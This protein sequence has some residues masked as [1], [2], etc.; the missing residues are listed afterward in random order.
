MEE[1]EKLKSIQKFCEEIWSPQ[2]STEKE[3]TTDAQCQGNMAGPKSYLSFESDKIMFKGTFSKYN[4]F[5]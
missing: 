3:I 2:G 5:V 4:R 1:K